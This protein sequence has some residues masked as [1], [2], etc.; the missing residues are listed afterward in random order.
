VTSFLLVE[1]RG[2][3]DVVGVDLHEGYVNSL[4]EQDVSDLGNPSSGRVTRQ[5][6]RRSG[7]RPNLQ[8]EGIC[9]SDL[10]YI[11]VDTPSNGG[12]HHYDVRYVG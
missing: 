8:E 10:I 5:G 6:R 4:N 12:E 7:Q 9:H 1:C 11:M 2:G 3:Y